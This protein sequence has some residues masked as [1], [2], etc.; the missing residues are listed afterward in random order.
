MTQIETELHRE[1]QLKQLSQTIHERRN[2]YFAYYNPQ[3][4]KG[5]LIMWSGATVTLLV[6]IMLLVRMFMQTAN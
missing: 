6:A 5:K 2:G 4:A 1:Q 3:R